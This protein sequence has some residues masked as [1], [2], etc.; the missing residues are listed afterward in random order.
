[1]KVC[2]FEDNS[3]L[4][5]NYSSVEGYGDEVCDGLDNDYDGMLDEEI[6]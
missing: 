6:P 5:P 4:E 1:M 2:D 3:W